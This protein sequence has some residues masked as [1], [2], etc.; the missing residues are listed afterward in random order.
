[1]LIFL[2]VNVTFGPTVI[3]IEI[4]YRFKTIIYMKMIYVLNLSQTE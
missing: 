1:M 3:T 2:G 4:M